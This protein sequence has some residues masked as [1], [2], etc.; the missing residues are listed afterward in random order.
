MYF[1]KDIFVYARCFNFDGYPRDTLCFVV[2]LWWG[3]SR[4]CSLNLYNDYF[5]AV[6]QI[7]IILSLFVISD[8][9]FGKLRVTYIY[10]HIAIWLKYENLIKSAMNDCIICFKLTKTIII[11]VQMNGFQN[12]NLCISWKKFLLNLFTLVY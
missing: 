4:D 9:I 1:I 5:E 11:K 7:T 6:T 3:K 12:V 8:T 2:T 10:C